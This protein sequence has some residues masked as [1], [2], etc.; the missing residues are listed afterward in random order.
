MT[1]E[2]TISRLMFGMSQMARTHPNDVI[3]NALA[4]TAYKLE[5]YG[6]AFA[7]PL[8]EKDRLAIKFYQ[9]NK[10]GVVS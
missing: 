7:S 9:A 3:S 4:R 1:L 5:S 10:D 8:D 6:T 2:L